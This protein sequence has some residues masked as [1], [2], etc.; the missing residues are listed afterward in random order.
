MISFMLRHISYLEDNLKD[1]R[2]KQHYARAASLNAQLLQAR[3]ELT[4]R[5]FAR[6][7]AA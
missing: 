7:G 3:T 2:R 4:E 6:S 1:A 5:L